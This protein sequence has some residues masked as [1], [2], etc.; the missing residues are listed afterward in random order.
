MIT[1]NQGRGVNRALFTWGLAM[2]LDVVHVQDEALKSA[3]CREIIPLLPDWFGMPDA[4]K[5]YISGMA[6]REVFAGFYDGK[7]MGFIGLKD[8]M[9]R[10][11]EVWWMGVVP[12]HHRQGIGKALMDTARE[13]ALCQGYE[14]M[15]VN[16]LSA[17]SDDVYYART[18]AFYQEYGFKALLEENE[19]DPVNPMIWMILPL[20]DREMIQ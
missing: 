5:N 9:R 4:N 20:N 12:Q 15:I 17:R 6:T 14:F 18:R 19:N 3:Y 7:L 10:S 8:H 13:Y 1:I 2:E 11:L 16:T